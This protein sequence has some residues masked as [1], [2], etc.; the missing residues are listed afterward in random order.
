MTLPE[1][2]PLTLLLTM[3]SEHTNLSFLYDP[4]EISGEVAMRIP[5]GLDGSVTVGQ[6]YQLL[7]SAVEV[8]NLTMSR[9]G[10]NIVVIVPADRATLNARTSPDALIGRP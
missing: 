1:R 6:L 9:R 7:E 2:V 10:D 8:K 4:D 5:G 3:V